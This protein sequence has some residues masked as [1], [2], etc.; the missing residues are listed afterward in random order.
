ML[1]QKIDLPSRGKA[2]PDS[3]TLAS[4]QVEMRYMTAAQDD[5][6]Q[7]VQ[8]IESGVL[9]D[10]LIKSMLVDPREYDNM[11]VGDQD[12]LMYYARIMGPGEEYEYSTICPK[13]GNV[14]EHVINLKEVLKF[15]DLAEE[16]NP[17]NEYTFVTPIGKNEI[18]F[19]LLRGKDNKQIQD[20]LDRYKKVQ[21]DPK[22]TERLIHMIISVD[23]ETDPAKIRNFVTQEFLLK[24]SRA[25][26]AEASRLM[27]G[28]D[29]SLKFSCEKCDHVWEQRLP[30]DLVNF[31]YPPDA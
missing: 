4:G 11:L 13:C 21:K 23:G 16:L 22:V 19:R 24:D 3:S 29:D 9:L 2:Y 5:I 7:N 25:F 1:T 14:E 27:P 30:L 8:L 20:M 12:A 31:F 6:L 26:K 28:V 10:V 18:K 17:D 15:R